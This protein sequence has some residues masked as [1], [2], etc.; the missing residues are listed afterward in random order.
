MK[1]NVVFYQLTCRPKN[2]TFNFAQLTKRSPTTPHS[3]IEKT[4]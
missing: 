2:T 1:F 4:C 3:D